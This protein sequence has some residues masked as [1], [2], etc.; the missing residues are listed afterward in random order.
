MFL[1]L[2][3][4]RLLDMRYFH[5][6]LWGSNPDQVNFIH[7]RN[8]GSP[9]KEKLPMCKDTKVLLKPVAQKDEM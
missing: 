5:Q 3:K 8:T 1:Q 4:D 9:P 7:F 6:Q 2:G